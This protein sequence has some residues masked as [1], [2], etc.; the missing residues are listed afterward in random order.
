[1]LTAGPKIILNIVVA[2]LAGY[3]LASLVPGV[4]VPWRLVLA[5]SAIACNQIALHQEK[6]GA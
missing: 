6:P 4:P 5:A 3:G 1:M 2:G